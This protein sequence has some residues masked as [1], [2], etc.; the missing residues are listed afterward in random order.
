MQQCVHEVLAISR[1][2]RDMGFASV[3]SHSPSHQLFYT[4]C[5]VNQPLQTSS[6]HYPDAGFTTLL[7]IVGSGQSNG[8]VRRRRL[9]M[10][11]VPYVTADRLFSTDPWPSIQ[12]HQ[13]SVA[14]AAFVIQLSLELCLRCYARS[15]DFGL[16]GSIGT[17]G[18]KFC[19]SNLQSIGHVPSAVSTRKSAC[20]I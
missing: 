5:Q 18:P 10:F 11:F 6:H 7:L 13:E 12:P 3:R 16:P 15:I 17:S 8:V 1:S 4:N 9:S 19:L 2:A 14:A 20:L